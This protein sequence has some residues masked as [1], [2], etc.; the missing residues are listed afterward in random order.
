MN[1]QEEQTNSNKTSFE[2][3]YSLKNN[4]VSASIS[5]LMNEV[6]KTISTTSD[7]YVNYYSLN[8]ESTSQTISYGQNAQSDN[9]SINTS[10][11]HLY[12]NASYQ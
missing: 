12:Q 5:Y 3:T 6:T 1:G 7:F 8:L 4:T 9:V 10:K 2:Y 11:T